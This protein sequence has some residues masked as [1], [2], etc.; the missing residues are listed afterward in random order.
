[1][2]VLT[3]L[4][5][6]M[7]CTGCDTTGGDLLRGT[8]AAVAENACRQAANCDLGGRPDPLA[9]KPAWERASGAPGKDPFPLRR[10]VPR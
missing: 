3:C 1:M 2:R 7:L 6:L 10:G 5:L 9:D 8:G 4:A